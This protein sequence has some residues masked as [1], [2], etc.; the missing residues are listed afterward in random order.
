LRAED[1]VA[2]A[3]EVADYAI[4]DE[5]AVDFAGCGEALA[6]GEVAPLFG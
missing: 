5:D 1:A 4:D 6:A 2:G 3:E